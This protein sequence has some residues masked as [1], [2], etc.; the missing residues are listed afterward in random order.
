MTATPA[1]TIL[2]VEDD[3]SLRPLLRRVL[4]G[5]GY[6]V[7]S[8]AEPFE[9]L[10]LA[11]QTDRPI[12]L[13]LTDVVMPNLS[14]RELAK[15]VSAVHGETRLLYMSGGTDAQMLQEGVVAGGSLFLQKPFGLTELSRR[16]REI[17]G[18]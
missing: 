2:L 13:L 15:R 11:A 8:A 9:A 5:D 7:L 12:D 3:E 6:D 4:E 17:L 10:A 18:A 14:G 16:V 1:R